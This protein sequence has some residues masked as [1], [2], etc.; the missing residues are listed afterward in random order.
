[1]ARTSR[2]IAK[3]KDKKEREEEEER[4]RIERE[5][6][7]ER[8]VEERKKKTKIKGIKRKRGEEED[9]DLLKGEKKGKKKTTSRRSK[10]R[11]R[12]NKKKK[13]E[14]EKV[15]SD[16]EEEEKEETEE[17]E[18][19]EETETEE[20]EEEERKKGIKGKKRRKKRKLTKEE[21]DSVIHLTQKK[22]AQKLNV[23]ISS[24]KRQYY[25]LNKNL[26]W[27]K[28]RKLK[29]K[30]EIKRERK[31]SGKINIIDILQEEE[32]EDIKEEEKKKRKGTII[33]YGGYKKRLF[34]PYD[35]QIREISETELYISRIPEGAYYNAFFETQKYILKTTG[36]GKTKEGK[37]ILKANSNHINILKALNIKSTNRNIS[38]VLLDKYLNA[39]KT[40]EKIQRT[41]TRMIKKD[42]N[43]EEENLAAERSYMANVCARTDIFSHIYFVAIINYWCSFPSKNTYM[44]FTD[45]LRIRENDNMQLFKI[46]LTKL[47]NVGLCMQYEPTHKHI[48]YII[49]D[50]VK[51][52]RPIYED[53]RTN[54][55]L[56]YRLMI[57]LITFS[58]SIV[59]NEPS[60]FMKSKK[61]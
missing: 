19:E 57:T 31:N 20:E 54:H 11:K 37:K 45:Y 29:Y 60:F 25:A 40:D 34:N 59:T 33:Y 43:E 15:M 4:K 51:Y 47:G 32:E 13:E 42:E 36:E 28:K 9:M 39:H 58:I 24:L 22:A 23:C 49:T 3:L 12:V 44:I 55:I 21:I 6:E 27:T 10:T 46:K 30:E 61:F 5:E 41:T 17:E 52:K 2:R 50:Q 53:E 16:T 26:S 18:E 1:M 38:S 7:E 8:K 35:I 14:E 48:E 56:L